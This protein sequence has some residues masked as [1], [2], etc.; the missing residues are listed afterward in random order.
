MGYHRFKALQSHMN[1]CSLL[2]M[3][4][5]LYSSHRPTFEHMASHTVNVQHVQAKK[6]INGM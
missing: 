1:T 2:C 3:C 4:K 5:A 6:T